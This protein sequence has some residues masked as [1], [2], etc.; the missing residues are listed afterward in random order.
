LHQAGGQ[1][2]RRA[3]AAFQPCVTQASGNGKNP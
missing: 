2:K 1:P 3:F